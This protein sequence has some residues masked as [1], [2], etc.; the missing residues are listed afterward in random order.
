[1][2]KRT[3][4]KRSKNIS[5]EIGV[6]EVTKQTEID[7]KAHHY[8]CFTL[9]AY[10]TDRHETGYEEVR[11]RDKRQQEKVSAATFII[12]IIGECGNKQQACSQTALQQ[13][14]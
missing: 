5:Q 4:R 13:Q 2:M 12:E 3:A 10:G 6:L 8:P 11:H 14:I 1:M 7:E 9:P